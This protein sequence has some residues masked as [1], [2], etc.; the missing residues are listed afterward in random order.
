MIR[1]QR[2]N[3]PSDSKNYH[4]VRR[5]AESAIISV[6]HAAE[7]QLIRDSHLHGFALNVGVQHERGVMEVDPGADSDP[8]ECSDRENADV[9]IILDVEDS[10]D[11]EVMCLDS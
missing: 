6:I 7:P 9:S 4:E 3:Y 10:E 5:P 2:L 8:D 1:P 11:D